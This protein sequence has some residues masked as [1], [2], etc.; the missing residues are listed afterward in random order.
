[1]IL[2][3]LAVDYCMVCCLLDGVF[4]HVWWGAPD[5]YPSL[6]PL[7]PHLPPRRYVETWRAMVKILKSGKVKAIGVST[8]TQRQIQALID[9][10]G[11]VPAV[12]QCEIHPYLQQEGLRRYCAERGIV[13]MA[14]SPLGR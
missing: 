6:L 8:F 10:S 12:N 1:M 14:Y 5:G 11:V 7:L 2:C 3:C 4:S 13:M 9:D